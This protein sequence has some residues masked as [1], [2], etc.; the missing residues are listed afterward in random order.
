MKAT[1]AQYAKTLY[2]L[3]KDKKHQE[4]DG[5][6]SGFLKTLRRNGEIRKIREIEGKFGKIYDAENGIVEAEKLSDGLK[7][8]LEKFVKEKYQA[9]EVV[10][11]QMIDENIRGGII[12]KV[13]D[14]VMDGSV[15]R[16]LADL[17]RTLSAS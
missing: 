2:E 12:I 7:S 17:R 5:V 9:K 13:G 3:T 15:D 14:E 6:I 4:I 8:K 16:Q 11:I 10:L 1:T